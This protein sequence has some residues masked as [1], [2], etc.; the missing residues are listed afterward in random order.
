MTV[1]HRPNPLNSLNCS[2]LGLGGLT[3]PSWACWISPQ[4]PPGPYLHSPHD[5]GSISW[6]NWWE[7]L[8]EI[9]RPLMACPV[10]TEGGIIEWKHEQRLFQTRSQ[11]SSGGIACL[12]W[13]MNLIFRGFKFLFCPAPQNGSCDSVSFYVG[14]KTVLLM[15]NKTSLKSV[16]TLM[17]VS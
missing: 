4:Y 9:P 14:S 15:C 8:E 5:Q 17:C 1:Q 12:D 3:V 7:R 10:E 16:S 13:M 2:V 11:H 6:P